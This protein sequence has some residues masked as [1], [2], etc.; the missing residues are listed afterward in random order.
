MAHLRALTGLEK[1]SLS[2]T[3]VTDRGTRTSGHARPSCPISICPARTWTMRGWRRRQAGAARGAVPEFR[4]FQRRRSQGHR[5]AR[6]SS[7]EL[8]LRDTKADGRRNGRPSE[9]WRTWNR[10]IW[11]TR[12]SSDAGIAKLTGLTKL[13]NLELDSVDLT[14][15]GVAHVAGL[16][17]LKELDLYHTLVTEKG[18]QQLK[19]A[20]A[21]LPHSLR[22]RL[23]Q[24]RAEE[25]SWSSTI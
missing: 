21:R 14:D 3:D 5:G 16:R 17:S 20:L 8:G 19:T 24:A 12:T 11:T 18:F 1:L 4:P 15:A 9:S 10:W 25:L 2:Y 22:S 13:I 23:H 7:S 6:S